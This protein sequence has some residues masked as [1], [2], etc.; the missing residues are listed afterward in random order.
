MFG[1]AV[2]LCKSEHSHPEKR[3]HPAYNVV[4]FREAQ[5]GEITTKEKMTA[6]TSL[7][8]DAVHTTTATC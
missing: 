4:L 8:R 6:L 7:P 2:T 1:R 3:V 5:K